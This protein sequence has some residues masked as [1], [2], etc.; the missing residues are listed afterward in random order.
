MRNIELRAQKKNIRKERDQLFPILLLTVAIGIAG[1]LFLKKHERAAH[2]V[3]DQSQMQGDED[4]TPRQETPPRPPAPT[5][6]TAPQNAITTESGRTYYV[7]PS[8]PRQYEHDEPSVTEQY[9]R[10]SQIMEDSRNIQRQI[11]RKNYGGTGVINTESGPNSYE[12]QS[13]KRAKEQLD[14][15]M[16]RYGYGNAQAEQLHENWRA[17]NQAMIRFECH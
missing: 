1:L 4:P 8:A 14:E 5:R 6:R 3:T 7:P 16:R 2:H 15:R 9:E 13:I 17:L 11:D 10:A 12:C